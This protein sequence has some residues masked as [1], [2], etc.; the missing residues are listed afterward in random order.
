M[1]TSSLSLTLT[2]L[3]PGSLYEFTISAMG[4]GGEVANPRMFVFTTKMEGGWWVG[5]CDVHDLN[6]R[7]K[8]LSMRG[9]TTLTPN[10]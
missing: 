3:Q 8:A 1:N 6:C 2:P 10:E 9:T 5:G 4:P 7:S